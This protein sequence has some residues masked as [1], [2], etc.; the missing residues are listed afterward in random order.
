[1]V[2]WNTL[3]SATPAQTLRRWDGAHTGPMGGKH[4]LSVLLQA[5]AS[6]GVPLV[7]GWISPNRPVWRA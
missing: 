6:Q 3:P 5:A 7:P 2:F 1:M 4:G